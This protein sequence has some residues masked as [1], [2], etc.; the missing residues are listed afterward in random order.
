VKAIL[1]AGEQDHPGYIEWIKG[2]ANM[3]RVSVGVDVATCS[4]IDHLASD[5]HKLNP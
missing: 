3:A 5:L 4:L 2:I 1:L